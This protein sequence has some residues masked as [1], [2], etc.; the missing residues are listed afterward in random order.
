[1]QIYGIVSKIGTIRC[2]KMCLLWDLC[3]ILY[4]Q[5][6]GAVK[7][8]NHKEGASFIT[9]HPLGTETGKYIVA[10]SS[11]SL[12]FLAFL[13]QVGDGG[14]EFLVKEAFGDDFVFLVDE[15]GIG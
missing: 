12:G 10:L 6:V 4:A 2:K 5:S 1:M 11:L 9:T 3:K 7:Y 13:C 15:N 14:T 8:N